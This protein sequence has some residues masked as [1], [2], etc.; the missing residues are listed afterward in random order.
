VTHTFTHD[1]VANGLQVGLAA[2]T[3]SG[4]LGG[5]TLVVGANLSIIDPVGIS[6]GAVVGEYLVNL[7]STSKPIAVIGPEYSTTAEGL[8]SVLTPN[9][10]PAITIDATSSA[11]NE[12][13]TYPYFVRTQRSAVAEAR[14]LVSMAVYLGFKRIAV[15]GTDDLYSVTGVADIIEMCLAD[16]ITVAYVGQWA[17]GSELEVVEP[18]VQK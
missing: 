8:L 1:Q 6:A 10:M 11:L 12:Q 18:Y 4:L 13:T 2:V 5:A 15:L 16:G 9:K 3:S 7:P 14:A 17:A